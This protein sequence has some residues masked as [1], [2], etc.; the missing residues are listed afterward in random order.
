M[1]SSEKFSHCKTL[2]IFC[3]LVT[4]TGV[5][6]SSLARASQVRGSQES[7][8]LKARYPGRGL[9]IS[10]VHPGSPAQRA[11]LEPRDLIFRYGS[12]EIVDDASY[13]A[14]RDAYENGREL[15][16]PIVVWRHGQ[17][18]RMMV[19]PGKLGIRIQRGRSS[20]RP[21]FLTHDAI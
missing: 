21:V 17:A 3:L 9:Q 20:R 10:E 16:I 14:A 6:G 18:V 8:S 4:G 5:C 1:H 11:G 7:R 12:F 2:L 19:E 13:F 15:E